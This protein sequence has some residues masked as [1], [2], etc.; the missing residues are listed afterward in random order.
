LKKEHVCWGGGGGVVLIV[1]AVV[2][3]VMDNWKHALGAS[4]S[5]IN[6]K[7]LGGSGKIRG[8]F[9]FFVLFCPVKLTHTTTIYGFPQMYLEEKRQRVE[10]CQRTHVIK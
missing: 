8:V 4:D 3:N 9:F 5:E 1:T 2:R 6:V 7:F 10:R